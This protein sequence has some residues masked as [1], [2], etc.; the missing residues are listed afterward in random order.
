MR[1]RAAPGVRAAVGQAVAECGDAAEVKAVALAAQSGSTVPVGPDGRPNR[2]ITWMDTRAQPVVDSWS[3]TVRARVR[4]ISG[5]SPGAGVGLATI[6][7]LHRSSSGSNS[8]TGSTRSLERW[9]S[10]DDHLVHELT[11]SWVTN[12]SNAAGMQLM[13]AR[14]LQWSPEL[15][16]LVDIDPGRLSR[17]AP[18]GE[19]L[20]SVAGRGEAFGLGRD[21]RLIVGGHDQACAALGLGALD[22]GDI[23]LSGGTAW[24]LSVITP[25]VRVE[26]LPAGF[27]LSPH[28]AD[29]RWSA[30]RNLGPLGA[31]L[32]SC[33]SAVDS[34]DLERELASI[35]PSEDDHHFVPNLVDPERT[36]WGELIGAGPDPGPIGRTRAAFEA[37]AFAVRH[38]I[39]QA[40][41]PPGDRSSIT[42][43]GG[44]TRSRHLCQQIADA[45]SRQVLIFPDASWPA[46]GAARIAATA[47][48]L[49]FTVASP[50]EPSMSPLRVDPRPDIDGIGERRY[51]A[52][53][54]LISGDQP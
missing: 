23:V 43:V 50:S 18:S 10:V 11:G 39:D 24:V 48:G 4:S 1:A 27:N 19:D 52:H 31:V 8:S 13:D 14:E 42:F 32:A 41:T 47:S 49:P 46:I 33:L 40:P 54:Q 51:F 9:A 34:A 21:V 36:T 3:D 16:D 29:Q 22:P 7:W 25:L 15:C 26:S 6:A 35:A 38:T 28:V 37:C 45:T 53:R 30:S 20:G 5:W 2:V 17:I 44:G 12:P